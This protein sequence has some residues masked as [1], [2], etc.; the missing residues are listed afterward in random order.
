[1]H[2]TRGHTFA[3]ARCHLTRPPSRVLELSDS[4]FTI[5][6]SNKSKYIRIFGFQFDSQTRLFSTVRFC[7]TATD[8]SQALTYSTTFVTLRPRQN[9][10]NKLN[11]VINRFSFKT[12][13]LQTWWPKRYA[14]SSQFAVPFWGQKMKNKV[15]IM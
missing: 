12:R 8:I 7:C 11:N 13:R 6:D 3:S 14:P 9:T 4:P 2:A 15:T 5:T 1:M 10:Q